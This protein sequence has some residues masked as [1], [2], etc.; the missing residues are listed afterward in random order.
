MIIPLSRCKAVGKECTRAQLV[1]SRHQPQRWEGN[2]WVW[3]NKNRCRS[4]TSFQFVQ[5]LLCFSSPA[6]AVF[7]LVRPDKGA[8]TV[9][10]VQDEF[11]KK[12]AKL[13][14][15]CTSFT[16]KGEGQST[17]ACTFWGSICILGHMKLTFLRSDI[18]MVVKKAFENLADV[19]HMLLEGTREN[20]DVIQVDEHKLVEHIS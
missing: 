1:V 12:F 4:K 8:A 11:A 16:D 13:R 2:I 17:T 14:K 9:L 18:K 5:E 7:P 20:E 15:R 6:K 19:F 3:E 10:K